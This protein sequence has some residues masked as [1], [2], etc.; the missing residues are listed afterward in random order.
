MSEYFVYMLRCSDG[1]LYTGWTTDIEQRVMQ[2]NAGKGSKYT[3]SRLPVA[4]VYSEE[5]GTKED[6]MRRE[7]EIKQ[8]SRTKKSELIMEMG[9]DGRR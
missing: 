7:Y 1:S 9:G 6:A 3:R 8:L 2:H 4:C 5:F